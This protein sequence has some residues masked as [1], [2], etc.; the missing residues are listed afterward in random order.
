MSTYKKHPKRNVRTSW[1]TV[2]DWYTGWV[3]EGGTRHH[4]KQ[5]IP[6]AMEMLA[7]R[8]GERIIDIGCG[9]GVL[10]P[11]I[12]AS[13]A[14]YTGIDVSP[15]ML[16]FAR[17]HHKQHGR[18]LLADACQLATADGLK[19]NSYDGAVFLL[20]IQDMDPLV[21]ALDSMAWALRGGGRVVIV[22][23]HPCFRIPRLSG[24]GWDE[25]RSL[26]FRRVDRYLTP[27]PVP[28]DAAGEHGG[29]TTT[30]FHR[31]LQAYINGLSDCGFAVDYLQEIA[32]DNVSLS[33]PRARAEHLA[34]EEIPVFLALRARK[35]GRN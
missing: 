13:G 21:S 20:S 26:Q 32:T 9:P 1:E 29:S 28:V 25:R 18:F 4:R 2:A 6:A 22:M 10:A 24:W 33:G 27:L 31:P 3:G 16:S 34:M 11:F 19:P 23:T 35:E 5:T 8:P 15:R 14:H 17:R 7:P 12:A 30:R